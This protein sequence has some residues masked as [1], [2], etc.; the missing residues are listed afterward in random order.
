MFVVGQKVRCKIYGEGVV[1]SIDEHLTYLV[2]VDFASGKMDRYTEDGKLC[3]GDD[4]PSLTVIE[5]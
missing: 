4:E 3:E 5:E 1:V 2:D